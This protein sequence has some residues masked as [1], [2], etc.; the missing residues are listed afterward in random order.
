MNT[1]EMTKRNNERRELLNKENLKVYEDA[2]IY[3]RLNARS[4]YATES[5][6][7]ELLEHLIE[8]QQH[9]KSAQDVFGDDLHGYC[10]AL[11]AD[12]PHQSKQSWILEILRYATILFGGLFAVYTIVQFLAYFIPS[13][14]MESISLV[15]FLIIIAVGA[16]AI[17]VILYALKASIFG[18]KSWFILG[19]LVYVAAVGGYAYSTILFKGIWMVP[20]SFW[21]CLAVTIVMILLHQLFKRLSGKADLKPYR[22]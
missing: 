7:L 4:E 6:L 16:I 10:D 9:G 12:I 20:M 1:I 19:V 5:I 2:M 11:I 15:P 8:A 14:K 13:L 22:N 18:T 21:S 17:L 3:I